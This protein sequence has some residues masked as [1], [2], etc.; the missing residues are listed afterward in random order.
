MMIK[1]GM[2]SDDIDK[3]LKDEAVA[4]MQEYFPNGGIDFDDVCKLYDAINEGKIPNVE[5]VN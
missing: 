1:V 4:A 5:L 3:R 2:S